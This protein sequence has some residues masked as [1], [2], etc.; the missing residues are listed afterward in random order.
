MPNPFIL[1]LA[2]MS[3]SALASEDCAAPV[4]LP[5]DEYIKTF[6]SFELTYFDGRGLAEVPRTLFA[7]AGRLPSHGFTDV[8][9]SSE[10]FAAAQGS[11]DLAKNL[12]RVPVLNHNGEV[13]GQSKAIARCVI[14]VDDIVAMHYVDIFSKPLRWSRFCPRNSRRT[15]LDSI[16]VSTRPRPFARYLAGQFGLMGRSAAEAAQ[17]DALCEH[18]FDV[19]AA[20]RKLVP[21][22]HSM[23]EAELAAATATWLST[24]AEP[25]LPGRAE[26]QLRWFLGQVEGQL[27]AGARFAVGDRPSLADAYLFNLLGEVAPELGTAGEPFGD[28]A[29]VGAALEHYPKIAGI[30]AQF[31]ASPGMTAYLNSRGFM[32]F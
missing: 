16:D 26:R 5:P 8:R 1:T 20:F 31:K 25:K 21:Y 2:L 6:D 17:I 24:P 22:G 3:G 19:Q 4:A 32:G 18:V 12:N 30:V 29:G 10:Q 9:L 14:I 7:T 11:G 27:P 23:S 15:P 28:L 13:I